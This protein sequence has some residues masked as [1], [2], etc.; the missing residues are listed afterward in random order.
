[1]G[2]KLGRITRPGI[3]IQKKIDNWHVFKVEYHILTKKGP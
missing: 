3:A 1:M 2:G